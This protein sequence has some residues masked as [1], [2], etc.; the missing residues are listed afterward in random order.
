MNTPSIDAAADRAFWNESLI[1]AA[2]DGDIIR[3]AKAI[4]YGADVCAD[5]NAPMAFAAQRGEPKIIEMLAC[6]GADVSA[7]D[8]AALIAAFSVRP[9]ELRL[10]ELLINRGANV[11][12]RDDEVFLMSAS[13]GDAVA[14]AF[15]LNRAAF[16]DAVLTEARSQ[17]GTAGH[18]EVIALLNAFER[19]RSLLVAPAA[20]SSVRHP[21]CTTASQHT[22][23][24][25]LRHRLCLKQSGLGPSRPVVY[26]T[27]R[28]RIWPDASR[29]RIASWGIGRM[30]NWYLRRD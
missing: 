5:N 3:A 17:A 26:Q 29:R 10:A 30:H 1:I 16:P 11:H 24:S 19:H 13:S 18:G 22:S 6:L 28:R 20:A 4:G 25:Q 9:F 8:D 21:P 15:L 7:D 12:A 14:V 27:P 2:Q 23:G